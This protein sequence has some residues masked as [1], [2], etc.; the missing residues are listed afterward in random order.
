MAKD[1]IKKISFLEAKKALIVNFT[2]SSYHWGCY[3]TSM[4]I[5]HSLLEKDYYVETIDVAYTHSLSPTIENGSDFDDR[6]F[7]NRFTKLNFSLI[8][9]LHQ[10]DVVVVNGEGTLHRLSKAALNLLYIMY[11]SKKYLNKKVHLINFSCFPNGNSELPK[12]AAI[13]YPPCIKFLDRVVTRDHISN[14]ILSQCGVEVTQSFDCLPRFLARYN[15]EN[16]HSPTGNILV[17][18]GVNFDDNR[19]NV[20]VDF[21]DYFLKKNVSVTFLYGAKFSP[22]MEDIKLHKKL[23]DSS[24]LSNLKVVEAKSMR[25]WIDEFKSA[26]FL[27]SARFHYSLAALSIGTPFRYFDSNTPKINAA[28]ETIDEDINEFFVNDNDIHTLI[29]SAEKC[30]N[31]SVSIKSKKRLDTMV[32]LANENF[33]GL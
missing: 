31:N 21:I 16:S 1:E 7:F 26:S 27:F 29:Y 25:Q 24:K 10:A 4:E 3:G 8:Q 12:G 11:I 13:I 23:K 20:M 22:A 9:S 33:V 19:Y 6:D 5:Y 32:S 2:G 30:L 17:T 15:E 18:G 28:L 14:E